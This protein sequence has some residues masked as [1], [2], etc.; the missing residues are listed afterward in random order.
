MEVRREKRHIIRILIFLAPERENMTNNHHTCVLN[1]AGA[2]ALFRLHPY[3]E[4]CI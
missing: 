1:I 2:E 3:S 4:Q